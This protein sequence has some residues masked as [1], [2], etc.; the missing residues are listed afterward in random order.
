MF[1]SFSTYFYVTHINS[2][3]ANKKLVNSI[4]GVAGNRKSS[5]GTPIVLDLGVF[6]HSVNLPLKKLKH[7][8]NSPRFDVFF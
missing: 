6:C 2:S 7:I 1:S 4:P 8:L 3:P 5:C